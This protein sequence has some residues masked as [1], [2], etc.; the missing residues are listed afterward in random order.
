MP[1]K[2]SAETL[3]YLQDNLTGI[4]PVNII[5][6]QWVKGGGVFSYCDRAIPGVINGKLIDIADMEAVLDISKGGTSTAVS[7]TLDDS[8]GT[9]KTIF[10]VNDIYGR[11]VIIYQWFTGIPIA[12]A[13]PIFEGVIASPITWNEGDRSFKF[14]VVTKI[15]DEQVGFIVEDGN[16]TNVP[17]YVMNK[18]WP[19]IFGTVIDMPC[20]QMDEIPKGTLA[21]AIGIPDANV[22]AQ[23]DYMQNKANGQIARGSCLT[24]R[25]AEIYSSSGIGNISPALAARANALENQGL[26]LQTNANGVIQPQVNRLN[27]IKEAQAAFDLNS[28]SVINGHRFK[29]GIA[30]ELRISG[31]SYYG[32]FSGDT[33][34]VISR[35]APTDDFHRAP[36]GALVSSYPSRFG[37]P[38]QLDQGSFDSSIAPAAQFTN[39]SSNGSIG[40]GAGTIN[41]TPQQESAAYWA[42]QWPYFFTLSSGIP[43]K[44]TVGSQH[45]KSFWSAQAGTSVSPGVD[46][47]IR[48]IITTMPG[49]QLLYLSAKDKDSGLELVTVIPPNYYYIS[50]MVIGNVTAMVATFYQPLSTIWD[51]HWGDDVYATVKSPVGPNVVD[52]IIWLIQNYT[53]YGIDHATFNHVR[54]LVE[55]YPAN[56]PILNKINIVPLLKDIAWQSRCALWVSEDYWYIK[57][58]PEQGTPVDTITESDIEVSTLEV[59]CTPTEEL[60]T[61]LVATFKESL[62]IDAPVEVCL[63]SNIGK[64]G[65]IEKTYNFYIY[66]DLSYVVKSATYWAMIYSNVWKVLKCKTFIPKLTIETLDNLTINLSNN[67]ACTGAVVGSARKATFNSDDFSIDLEV[68]LPVRLGTMKEYPLAYPSG[69]ATSYVWPDINDVPGVFVQNPLVNL[70]GLMNPTNPTWSTGGGHGSVGGYQLSDLADPIPPDDPS[71]FGGYEPA[72]YGDSNA[73]TI[74]QFDYTYRE[75]T[76]TDVT[77]DTPASGATIPAKIVGS[78]DNGNYLADLYENGVDNDSTNTVPVFI[79]GLNKDATMPNYTD[80]MVAM[81]TLTD[82]SGYIDIQYVFTPMAFWVDDSQDDSEE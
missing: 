42:C 81:Q 74:P 5:S 16:F 3:A 22:G 65:T 68:W 48:Y 28:F 57:Y 79:P 20:V 34:N 40:S 73:P 43:L 36:G 66:N 10:D 55:N 52:I 31:A 4:E 49:A 60:V 24:G 14:D 64:Y 59:S 32:S 18:T 61:K 6:V 62:A 29:Q 38:V 33:F 75:P 39:N 69:I 11:K 70:H 35:M 77:P 80:G 45:Q 13:F 76:T 44:N 37:P 47:P 50:Y 30:M 53:T 27:A 19:L 56:F 63:Q 25:A 26:A 67:Y 82:S 71:Y 23:L 51:Q 2:I 1:R 46:Y 58:L 21:Q 7:V 54:V 9:I 41:S 72:G 8:D 78:D 12:D 15:D 17:T